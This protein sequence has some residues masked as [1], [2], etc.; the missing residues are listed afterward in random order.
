MK[1]LYSKPRIY[2]IKLST[3]EII[4][5]IKNITSDKP[6]CEYEGSISE[7]SFCIRS[8]N[9]SMLVRKSHPFINGKI[10]QCK[11]YSILEISQEPDKKGLVIIIG[12]FLISLIF[13]FIRVFK[14]CEVP[15]AFLFLPLI[16]PTIAFLIMSFFESI[17]KSDNIY[18]IEKLFENENIT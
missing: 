1:L 6:D 16:L 7:N 11:N 3:D 5:Q 9:S 13:F 12:T 10:T 18:T 17:G 14:G 8:K 15:V 4:S 2:K